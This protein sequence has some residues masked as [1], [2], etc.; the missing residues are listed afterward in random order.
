MQQLKSSLGGLNHSSIP[1]N[2]LSPRDVHEHRLTGYNFQA[3]QSFDGS[4]NNFNNSGYR[5]PGGA[6][7]NVMNASGA[8][9]MTNSSKLMLAGAGASIMGQ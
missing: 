8:L 7:A 1:S 3:K 5:S 4:A 6:N 2:T 9:N